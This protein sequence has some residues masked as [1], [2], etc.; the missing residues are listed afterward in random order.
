MNFGRFFEVMRLELSHNVRRPLFW[1]RLLILL[2]LAQQLASGNASIQSGD[3]R[4]GGTK[5]WLTSEFANTQV[6]VV[7]ISALYVFFLSIGAGPP[8]A[9]CA[10]I[11]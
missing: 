7:L 2:F 4:V 9:L 1:V 10:T 6:L 8:G 5:A 11:S 3:A